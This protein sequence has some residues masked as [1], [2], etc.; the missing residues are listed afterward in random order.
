[1]VIWRNN[2]VDLVEFILNIA[3]IYCNHVLHSTMNFLLFTYICGADNKP[4]LRTGQVEPRLQGGEYNVD[5]SINSS[6]LYEP[7][8][9]QPNHEP[10]DLVQT[11]QT[12]VWQK[13]KSRTPFLDKV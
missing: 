2:P 12:S 6:A 5:E 13:K 1:M 3:P 10:T 7:K 11:L 9:T 8:Q 4:G